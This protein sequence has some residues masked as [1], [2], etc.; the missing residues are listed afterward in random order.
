MA[1]LSKSID[2]TRLESLRSYTDH[3]R[4][5]TECFVSL[6][7]GGRSGVGVLTVPMVSHREPGWVI[8]HSFGM[9]QTYLQ[10]L[11]VALARSLGANGFPVLRF[12]GRGYGDSDAPIEE[13][14]LESHLGDAADAFRAMTSVGGVARVGLIGARFGGA[15]AALVADRLGASALV[16][17]DPAVS[18]KAYLNA[19]MRAG[20]V[21]EL[22]DQGR[23]SATA[24]DPWEV[25]DEQGLLE[26]HGFPLT[27]P[28]S[29]EISLLDVAKQLSRFTGDALVVQVSR[30]PRPGPGL[31]RLLARFG[32]LGASAKLEVVADPEATRFGLTRYRFTGDASKVDTQERLSATLIERT[33]AWCSEVSGRRA[34]E[35]A[36]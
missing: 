10:P 25:L 23:G 7:F 11:E 16:L 31:G 14:G 34:Q 26:V 8:C 29:D 36:G 18:G 6:E 17:L 2:R 35:E 28:A 15:V 20:L 30:S 12:Q 32:D 19:I 3:R 22:A 27:R 24:R 33:V 4:G 1:P 5:I 21:A 13:V 9:E